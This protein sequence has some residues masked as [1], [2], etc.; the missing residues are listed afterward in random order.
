MQKTEIL[1]Y[2]DIMQFDD[3]SEGSSTIDS[4][5]FYEYV[6]YDRFTGKLKRDSSILEQIKDKRIMVVNYKQNG[7][8]KTA[9][10]QLEGL[11]A[12][13]NALT[14]EDE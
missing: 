14:E 11:E 9:M 12:I 5:Y 4:G 10:F 1:Y 2:Y 6:Q 8:D 3:S 13:Y 7:L